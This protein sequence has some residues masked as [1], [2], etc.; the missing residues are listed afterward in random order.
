M[1]HQTASTFLNL[2]TLNS[3]QGLPFSLSL[4]LFQFFFWYALVVKIVNSSKSEVHSV[5]LS[6]KYP[7]TKNK[8][9]LTLSLP[10]FSFSFFDSSLTQKITESLHSSQ[11]WIYTDWIDIVLSTIQLHHPILQCF[12]HLVL[13]ASSIVWSG[14]WFDSVKVL[15]F[16]IWVFIYLF[17]FWCDQEADFW[18]IDWVF[19]DLEG[20]QFWFDWTV[21]EEA[22]SNNGLEV[23]C[24]QWQRPRC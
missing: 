11:H 20:S 4:S 3:Q 6:K 14:I 7:V 17:I 8:L 15:E 23:R 2:W 21:E 22:G 13:L 10:F 9:T 24:Q 1:H 19:I 5:T 18:C 12:S 16:H